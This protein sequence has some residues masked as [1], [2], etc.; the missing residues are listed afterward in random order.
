MI[1]VLFA[2]LTS[3][4]LFFWSHN[5]EYCTFLARPTPIVLKSTTRVE[6]HRAKKLSRLK[7]LW[8]IDELS[9]ILRVMLLKQ[10]LS[11]FILILE[12]I[13]RP[14][15]SLLFEMRQQLSQGHLFFDAWSAGQQPQRS[16]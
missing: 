6:H 10:S 5:T 11:G 8:A 15:N 9:Y 4:I 1:A 12:S 16:Y 13:P 14:F 2:C 3:I 7:L